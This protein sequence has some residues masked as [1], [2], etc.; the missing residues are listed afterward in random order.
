MRAAVKEFPRQSE[1]KRIAD[2][3]KKKVRN[4]TIAGYGV[5]DTGDSRAK[6]PKLQE[7]TKEIRKELK[8]RGK[9]APGAQPSKSQVYRSGKLL[10]NTKT[11]VLKKGFKLEPGNNKQKKYAADLETRGFTWLNLSDT[12]LKSLLE[13]LD[14]EIDAILNLKLT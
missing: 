8:K 11:K 13:Q 3:T 6:L 10:D 12:E 9:L 1:M 5:K 14:T 2:S 4:R 7:A